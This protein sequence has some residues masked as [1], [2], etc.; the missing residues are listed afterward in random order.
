MEWKDGIRH[1]LEF[2]DSWYKTHGLDWPEDYLF[3]MNPITT[4]QEHVARFLVTGKEKILDVGAGPLTVLGK[5]W[6]GND[7]SII[8]CDAL[9]DYYAEMNEKYGIIPLVQTEKCLAEDLVSKYGTDRFEIVHAQNCIDHCKDPFLAI[10]EMVSV[11]KKGG[12]VLLLHEVNEAENEGY[13]GFHQWNFYQY[14][15]DFMISGKDES[16]NITQLLGDEDYK[17]ETVV[18]GGYI[19]NIISK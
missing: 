11:L 19:S 18:N 7:L 14:N 12:K 1:E 13:S 5:Q 3:R 16:F 9:A 2:W 17:V 4:L 10:V 8:A 15:G 6:N